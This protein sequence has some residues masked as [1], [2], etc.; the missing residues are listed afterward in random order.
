MVFQPHQPFIGLHIQHGRCN[1]LKQQANLR[2]GKFDIFHGATERCKPGRV[3][4]FVNKLRI[5]T[6]LEQRIH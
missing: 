2:A 1:T 6:T 4:E 3:A 5:G